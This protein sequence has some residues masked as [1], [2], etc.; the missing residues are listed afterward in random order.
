MSSV[1]CSVNRLGSN[2]LNL[3]HLQEIESQA[4]DVVKKWRLADE[5]S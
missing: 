4:K 1:F 5:D 2:S 3:L